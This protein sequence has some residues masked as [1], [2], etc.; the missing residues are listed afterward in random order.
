[1]NKKIKEKTTNIIE[2]RED[3][4]CFPVECIY[5]VRQ[6]QPE[7]N[8]VGH[9]I[10]VFTDENKALELSRKLNKQ[11]GSGCIF[12]EDGD[13]MEVEDGE[14]AH[15]YDVDCRELNPDIEKFL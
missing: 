3:G 1:M 6:T 9:T 2:Q 4:I 7:E 10:G 14:F 12:D 13:L 15:Y 11:Y 8:Y 5:L